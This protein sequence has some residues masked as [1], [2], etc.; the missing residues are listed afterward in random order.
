MILVLGISN[1]FVPKRLVIDVK[2]EKFCE[3]CSVDPETGDLKFLTIILLCNFLGELVKL[4]FS[5][6][7]FLLF[8]FLLID[9]AQVCDVA[10]RDLLSVE[11]FLTHELVVQFVECFTVVPSLSVVKQSHSISMER[12]TIVLRLI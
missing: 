2:A 11:I 5:L 9:T 1:R 10:F 7:S 12:H 6:L 4:A 8:Q 3:L